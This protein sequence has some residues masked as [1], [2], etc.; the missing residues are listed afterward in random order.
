MAE[1]RVAIAGVGNC[2]SSLVQGVDFYKAMEARPGSTFGL[3]HYD[4]G[5]YKPSDIRFV[6]AFDIDARKVGRPLR[7]AIFVKPNCTKIF[8]ENVEDYPVIVEMGKVLDSVSPHMEDY[9]EDLRFVVARKKPSD[10][11][12]VL[13]KSGAEILLNYLPVGSEKATAF[14]AE[15]CL[16]TGVSLINCIPVFIA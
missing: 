4:L 3:M 16:K 13:K 7:E 8:Y 1:I 9:P 5:G 12:K 10:V 15:A 6:A 11:E 14:Y 2:A